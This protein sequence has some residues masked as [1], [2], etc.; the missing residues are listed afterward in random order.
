MIEGNDSR[1]S[2]IQCNSII[3]NHCIETF[4]IIQLYVEEMSDPS[5]RIKSSGSVFSLLPISVISTQ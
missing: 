4:F 2:L 3:F 1:L 5:G